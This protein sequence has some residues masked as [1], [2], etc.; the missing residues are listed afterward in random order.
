MKTNTE[1]R[2]LLASA[3][4][5]STAP[6]NLA[7]VRGPYT[8]DANTVVLLHLDE[9]ST[10]GIAV[11]SAG[12]TA[13]LNANF[14][15]ASNPS[16]TT[17]RNPLPGLLGAAGAT[18]PGFNYGSAANLS[19]SN[20]LGIFMDANANGVADLDTSSARGAD[21]LEMWQFCGPSGE[22]TLEALVNLPSLTGANREII[23]MDSG[24]SPRPYQFRVTSTGQLEFNNIGNAGANPKANIP[25]TGPEAFVANQWFHV[26]MT[27]DGMDTI[28]FYWTKL[29]NSRVGATLLQA[30]T[31]IPP[32]VESGAAVLTIGNENRNTSGEGLLGLIDEV[33]I[34]SVVRGPTEMALDANAPAIPPMISVEPEDQLLGVGETLTIQSHASGSPV[35]SYVWQKGS[36]SVFTSLPGQTTEV[37][38]LPVTFDT[39][40]QYRYI[41][42]ND[43]GSVTSRVATISVGSRFTG[44]FRT[45]FDDFNVQLGDGAI[46]P[47]YTLWQTADAA[48]LGP[49]MIATPIT[50][51]TYNANDANSRWITPFAALG[52]GRGVYTYRTTFVLDSTVPEGASLSSSILAAGPTVVLL[53]GQPTGIANLAP[54]FPGPYRNLFSFTVTNGFLPGLNTLDFVVDNSTTA[55]NPVYGTALR[56]TS[57][58]GIGNAVAPGVPAIQSQPA[59]VTVREGGRVAFSVVATGRPNLLYQWYDADS[60][61]PIPSATN[62]TLRFNP[63]NSGAQ[64]GRV[65]VVVRNDSGSITSRVANLTL[66][67]ANRLPV[68]ATLELI[69]FQGQ[70]AL[71]P[72]S[73][74]ARNSSDPDND[75]MSLVL[76]SEASTNSMSYGSNNL[77]LAGANL[78]YNPVEGFVGLDQFSYGLTDYETTPVEGFVRVLSLAAPASFTIA[79]GG[80]ATFSVGLSSVPA[81]FAF[82]WSRNGQNLAGQTTH[83]L[84]ISNAQLADAGAYTLEVTGLSGDQWVSPVGGLIVGS[85]GTGSGLTG[86]YY[87]LINGT[88][89]FTG[90]VALTRT[91]STID[92]NWNG[93]QPDP[94][95]NGTDF[96]ARW[97]GS[98]EPIYSD[99]YTFSTVTDDGSRLWVDGKLLVNDWMA[100]A[101]TTN[102]GSITLTAGQKYDLVFEYYQGTG[103]SSARLAWQSEH[104]P[105]QTIPSTQLFPASGVLQ[106]RLTAVRFSGTN[107]VVDWAGTFN[108]Q[109]AGNLSSAWTT[110]ATN[111]IGPRTVMPSATGQG[112]YRLTSPQ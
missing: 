93:E 96:M 106:P 3:L 49:D 31:G 81:G 107:V 52:G 98:V 104:Q 90:P 73:D 23:C 58:R 62:W 1:T 16:G 44:L 53:N 108:L 32:L 51:D 14:I 34:S 39:A 43:H 45:G 15:A 92:F 50:D 8:P 54:A 35:L 89:N 94:A 17:P 82:Q 105:P 22:F 19:Y 79:P 112:F 18:G 72:V 64:P 66:V 56:V 84:V 103:A 26:A 63:V 4:L 91:D 83:Q 20:N 77:A 97:H 27:W 55:V 86:N 100:H 76:V 6:P 75:S 69:S 47:H 46:D 5:L 70:P 60:G 10:T 28:N 25:T 78:V 21:Q 110:I 38:T 40:G 95:V 87:N 88:S 7:S 99:V 68:P 30:F 12:S 29:D 57:I 71:L 59:D 13:P 9:P 80:T 101:A 24:G 61:Q 36:D 85:P 11:N 33:R 48:A 109:S 42:S 102:S 67:Q 111:A 37:L 65:Q 2:L 74:V 41:V